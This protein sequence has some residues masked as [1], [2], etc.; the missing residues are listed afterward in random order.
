MKNTYITYL[1]QSGINN[2]ADNKNWIDWLLMYLKHDD[3]Q[4][5]LNS[6]ALNKVNI[7]NKHSFSAWNKW[8]SL[9]SGRLAF[10]TTLTSNF[11]NYIDNRFIHSPL[12]R[13]VGSISS[14][15][16]PTGLAHG[17]ITYNSNKIRPITDKEAHLLTRKSKE[18]LEKEWESYF[19]QENP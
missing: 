15:T 12:T 10:S 9:T 13:Y 1:D 19:K 6:L 17:A 8:T 2:K 18:D 5:Y 14:I 7:E 11:D 4:P 16:E 3:V